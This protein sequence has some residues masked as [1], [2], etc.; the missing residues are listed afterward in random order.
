MESRLFV[1]ILIAIVALFGWKYY[2]EVI[3]PNP[4]RYNLSGMPVDVNVLQKKHKDPPGTEIEIPTNPL[5]ELDGMSKEDILALRTKYVNSLSQLLR[6]R[7]RPAPSIFNSIGDKKPWWG[8]KG[9]F[10]LG[11]GEN[12]IAG[13]SEESRFL[14]NPFHL[15]Y[16]VE[17]QV[18]DVGE[19]CWPVFPKP[20][21]LVWS[22]EQPLALAEY[23]MSQFFYDKES[24]LLPSWE[25]S[26][27]FDR[28]NAVDFG[29][30]YVY[31]DPKRSKGI[32]ATQDSK[33]MQEPCLIKSSIGLGYS[34][35][36]PGGCNDSSPRQPELYFQFMDLPAQIYCLLW[37]KKPRSVEQPP[38][39]EFV[40]VLY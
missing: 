38:D 16:L 6:K 34:C 18:F 4:I 21:R 13:E 7:Y 9:Q 25:A 33:I 40:F 30:N 20:V 39:F 27:T 35:Q 31:I 2:T 28:I 37:K 5:V 17:G 19:K 36:Y 32:I 12:S 10:C 24:L 14:A 29:Y 11:I 26:F 23:Q 15:L 3:N 1:L 22:L 8:V